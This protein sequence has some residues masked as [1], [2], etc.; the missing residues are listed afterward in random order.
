M[1]RFLVALAALGPVLLAGGAAF[2][3]PCLT[4][5]F[6][7]I[8]NPSSEAGHNLNGW[9]PIEP[10]SSGGNFGGIA[11]CRVV[12][13]SEANGDGADWATVDLDFGECSI[14]RSKCLVIHHLDGMTKDAFD[15][16]IYPA[17]QPGNAKKIYSYPGDESTAETWL[18]ARLAANV[19]G[20]QTLK[21]VST[22]DPW[23]QFDL[24]GQLAID[25]IQVLE[26]EIEQD[27]IDIGDPLSES[28]HNLVGWGPIEPA[29]SGGSFGGID[30]CRVIYASLANGDGEA[31]AT[32]DVDLGDCWGRK[33]VSFLHLDGHTKDA[34]ETYLYASGHPEEAV[35]VFTYPGDDLTGEYW[36]EDGFFTWGT[37]ARTLKFVSTE[38][39]WSGFDTYG[40]V[41]FDW[42][43]VEAD[44]P[45]DLVDVGSP[46]SELGHNLTEWGPIE[47]AYSGGPYGGVID[48]RPIYG[49]PSSGDGSAWAALDLDF[50]G[51]TI[52]PKSLVLRHLDGLATNDAFDIYLSPLGNPWGG[53]L[54][55]SYPGD[56]LAVENWLTT[57]LPLTAVGWMTVLLVSTE[58]TWWGFDTYGQVCFDTIR[59]ETSVPIPTDVVSVPS[60]PR[61]AL[62]RPLG[63]NP[64]RHETALMLALPRPSPVD[65]AIYDVSGRLVRKLASGVYPAGDHALVWDG[66]DSGS[67]GLSTGIYFYRVRVPGQPQE[68]GKVV[69]VR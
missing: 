49:P 1:T 47:P 16:Y 3:D 34:F 57:D 4:V 8:G 66:R 2:A 46:D 45:F 29:Q 10:A 25:T 64:F 58:E 36:L 12:Y 11:D 7:D 35:L 21:L 15:L 63:P 24:Y 44:E 40:Q 62:L 61:P 28:G 31:W 65:A 5:D 33:R 53:V 19:S 54:V 51:C 67:R 38:P 56:G 32:V 23:D 43:S 26:C 39:P 48:C 41:A 69:L 42:I 52:M 27:Y 55:Y 30:D 60:A 50:G 13:A 37:G 20:S 18:V 22:E 59:V 6:V 68:T 17:G 14:H 9:G